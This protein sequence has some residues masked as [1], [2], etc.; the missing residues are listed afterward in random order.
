LYWFTRTIGSASRMYYES[1][2]DPVVLQPGQRVEVPCGFL[3][4]SAGDDRS[5][6][7]RLGT[8]AVPRTGA[9]PRERAERAFAVAR[10]TETAVGGHF[11]AL[12]TPELFV[13]EVRAFFRPM[14]SG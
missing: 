5:A 6:E 10:W 12:E 3:L 4:E 14:R 13:D 11:P 1:R 9:P 7:R 8:A 2:R